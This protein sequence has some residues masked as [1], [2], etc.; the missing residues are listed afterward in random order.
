MLVGEPAIETLLHRLVNGLTAM[1]ESRKERMQEAR[2][3]L[4][5]VESGSP[6]KTQS[7]YVKSCHF[8][9]QDFWRAGRSIDA[10][11][12]H[13]CCCQIAGGLE[14]DNPALEDLAP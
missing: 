1:G 14:D 2:I 9:L 13:D 3:W 5:K 6:G 10:L 7:W 4:W 12:R 11:K 8:K